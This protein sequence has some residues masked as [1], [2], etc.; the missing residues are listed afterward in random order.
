MKKIIIG[1]S[2]LAAV[3][4]SSALQAQIVSVASGSG[5]NIKAGTVI[6][7]EGLDLT[8]T[9]DFSLTSTLSRRTTVS[10]PTTIAH[11][12]R[13]YQF[14][15]TTSVF[16]GLLQI[17]YQDADLNGLTESSL[18]LL[19]NNGSFWTMD[20]GSTNDAMAN[21]VTSSLTSK[22]L[23]ELALGID[24][25]ASTTILNSQCGTT[26]TALNSVI[27]CYPV[28]NAVSY[29]FKVVTSGTNL[30][31][32]FISNTNSF[33]LTSVTG[34]SYNTHYE[35]SVAV[36]IGS[37][38]K[39]YGTACSITTPP[40]FTKIQ[41]S[42][43]GQ[44]LA[45]VNTIITANTIAGVTNYRFK[46]V[47]SGETKFVDS[48]TRTFQL[49]SLSGG[50]FF[51]TEYFISVA[52]K[53]NG[54]WGDYS[55]SC[56]VRTP[57]GLT[58]IQDSQCGQTLPSLNTSI[59]ANLVSEATNYRFKVV[60]NGETKF[61]D[62]TTR[63][64]QLTSLSGGTFFNTEYSISVASKYNGFWGDY[65]ISCVVRTPTGLTKIQD[66]QCGQTLPSLKTSIAANSVSLATNYRFKVV[67]NGETRLV[68]STSR[69]F[70]LT[71]LVGG[72][73]N[74]TAYTISVA[75]KYNGFWGDYGA[76]CIVKTPSTTVIKVVEP[77]NPAVAREKV[78]DD[79]V[80]LVYPSPFTTNFKL[81]FISSS[82][83]T[84]AVAVFDMTGRQIENR[85]LNSSEINN[86]ELGEYYSSG[87][88]NVF[89]T[90]G[91][92]IKNLRVI[93]K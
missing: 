28:T 83:S 15:A 36:T 65:G 40:P 12:N 75:T 69:T 4:Y 54:V 55:T 86:I 79:M 21:S 51:N 11:P 71:S 8:P 68:D 92:I 81:N 50:A 67:A 88:Y 41:D 87:V 18:K 52:T 3:L 33:N 30:I 70:Q 84:V 44:T 22:T 72:A 43:C 42:Q 1:F 7:A 19:Y 9:T 23:N 77:A 6:G 32:Y 76:S 85:M 46:V 63:T 66:S 78:L 14:E 45:S 53:Y 59:I 93:K 62:T 73:Q 13:S 58:K 34:T 39:A 56:V 10:N 26:L 89:V 17:N 5:F 49:T 60:A 64:F 27:T 35:I 91:A 80:V 37:Y 47:A 74:N 90:Q 29:R 16:S 25:G 48:T 31:R 82:S 2:V 24:N 61:V 20:Y 38:L 57:T